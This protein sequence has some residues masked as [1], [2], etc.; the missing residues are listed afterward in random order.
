MDMQ[1]HG[2]TI[3]ID[4][5]GDNCFVAIKAVGKLTHNDYER[6]T[7][8]L[9]AAMKQVDEPKINVLF[10]A[11]EFDG[12]ELRAAWDDFR[13]GIKYGKEFYKVALFGEHEWQSWATRV[14]SWFV[15]G[16][17]RNFTHYESAVLWLFD[18]PED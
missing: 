16:E 6:L 10:D 1:K 13:L 12:W 17:V 15:S 11:T 14:A 8:M 2:I 4:R 7:P 5:V 9:E 18:A 3:G